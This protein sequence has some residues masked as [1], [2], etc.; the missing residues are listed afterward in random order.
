MESGENL[1]EVFADV[2]GEK[3]M[4]IE[5]LAAMLDRMYQTYWLWHLTNEVK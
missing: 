5:E 2:N 1:H 3:E 4:S